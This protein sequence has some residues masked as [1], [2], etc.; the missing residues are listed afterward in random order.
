MVWTMIRCFGD[1]NIPDDSCLKLFW[2]VVSENISKGSFRSSSDHFIFQAGIISPAA[3]RWIY[4]RLVLLS[5][6]YQTWSS[7]LPAASRLWY[8]YVI[9]PTLCGCCEVKHRRQAWCRY[10]ED[11]VSWPSLESSEKPGGKVVSVRYQ[12]CSIM[13]SKEVLRHS[14][15]STSQGY[16]GEVSME[17]FIRLEVRSTPIWRRLS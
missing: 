12:F 5:V 3:D 13:S 1:L 14:W 9:Q 4:F 8:R 16:S 10:H 2:Q 11:H 17:N 15:I 6:Q 7:R